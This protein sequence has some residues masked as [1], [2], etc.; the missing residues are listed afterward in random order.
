MLF[1]C[2]VGI[3]AL[4]AASP[5][6]AQRK[7]KKKKKK[8][9]VP[10]EA[11]V[12]DEAAPA[13]PDA[14]AT[15]QTPE[16]KKAAAI[17]L[18]GEGRELAK[19]QKYDEAIKKFEEAFVLLPDPNLQ[20]MIGEAL[21]LD[22]TENRDYDKLRKSIEAYRR[23]VDLV[24]EGA[25]T[26]KANER[27][28]QLEESV[29]Q[30]EQRIARLADEEA[31]AKLDAELVIEKEEKKKQALLAKRKTMQIVGTGQV[32]AGADQLLSGILRMSGGGLLSWEKF[33]FEGRIGIDGFL[34]VD[35]EQGISARS[36]TLLDLG[37]RYGFN[38]RYVGPFISGGAG[39]GIFTGK[40][41]ER[42]LKDDNETCG[43]SGGNCSFNIDKN[44]STRLAFGYGFEASDKST[45]AFRLEVQ[46]WL[47]SVDDVQE[48]GSP[49]AFDV[50]KP[51]S[52]IA[53]MAG[54]EFMRW[55]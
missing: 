8:Q 23:Y 55:L 18:F 52:S 1:A 42:K 44:I 48:I 10:V 25:G 29:K 37:V 54:L 46:G 39:F 6:D 7:R 36:F 41:R 3:A 9:P 34:R 20:F 16:E 33:A 24:P 51:Q 43:F 38:Y 26:D 19:E 5:A 31:Q 17:V 2:L 49:P 14:P 4:L 40:P 12:E 11:P 21:Q 45:V 47:F 13:T 15:P 53:I 27:I 28:G 22:G 50:E 32:L 35:A 30:E